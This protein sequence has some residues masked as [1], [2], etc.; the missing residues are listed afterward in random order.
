M[1]LLSLLRLGNTNKLS[2]AHQAACLTTHNPEQHHHLA[3]GASD[4]MQEVVLKTPYIHSHLLCTWPSIRHLDLQTHIPDLLQ[5]VDLLAFQQLEF[6]RLRSWSTIPSSINTVDL[7]LS[8][9]ESLRHLHIE[10]WSPRSFNVTPRCRV[11]AKWEKPVV[12]YTQYGWSRSPCWID[13]SINLICFHMDTAGFIRGTSL[14]GALHTILE[15][16]DG[17]ESVRIALTRVG[18]VDAP[19]TFPTAYLQGLRACLTIEIS[20][21]DGCWLQLDDITPFSGRLVLNTKGPLHVGIPAA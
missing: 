9:A 11:Y 15:N 3:E 2:L 6:L 8:R 10:D 19:L 5:H 17:L 13:P 16:H 14:G 1:L 21:I 18:S 20:T 12:M 4:L 7:D